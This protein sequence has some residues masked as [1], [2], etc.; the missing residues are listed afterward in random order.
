M[1]DYVGMGNRIFNLRTS[2]NIKQR[3]MGQRLGIGQSAYSALE[4]GK[5]EMTI[6]Q[7]YRIADI[8]NVSAFW[9]LEPCELEV[10]TDA[11]SLQMEEYKRFIISRR[12]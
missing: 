10:L 11:E 7:L 2:K 9:I 8:L 6:D 5:K 12:K 4:T 3:E 1:F